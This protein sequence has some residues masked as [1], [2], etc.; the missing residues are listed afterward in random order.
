MFLV[1]GG[2]GFIGSHLVAALLARNERV[3]VLDN[4]S[5]GSRSRL[6]GIRSRIEVIE[7]DIRDAGVCRRALSGVRIVF[8]QAALP[9]VTRSWEDP[10]S[11]NEVNVGGTLNLL[12][13]AKRER[14]ERF[15]FASSSSV[16]GDTPTLPKVETMLPHPRS[17]YAVSKLAGESYCRAFALN[18]DVPAVALRYFNVYGPGQDPNSQY[19]AVIPRVVTALLGGQPPTVYGDGEQSRDFTYVADC[20]AANLLAAVAPEA[21]GDV[22]NVACGARTS[23][24]ALVEQVAGL[25]GQRLTPRHAPARAG[26]VRHSLAD[27]THA[28]QKLSYAPKYDF[29]AG[30]KETVQWYR[31]R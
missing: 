19:A 15:V 20:V 26:D 28:A 27:I 6:E 7:G 1:T 22:F 23:V 17:P 31:T 30:L 16:Y 3:R 10:I 14:I 29:A 21:A 9:S 12:E 4:F 2:A 13:A 5:T 11:T 18:G 24:N 25:L 8:H